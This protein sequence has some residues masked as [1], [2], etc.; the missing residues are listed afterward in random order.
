MKTAKQVDLRR[1]E[2]K[3]VVVNP[4]SG[5][6]I[7]GIL[8]DSNDCTIPGVRIVGVDR[9]RPRSKQAHHYD[10]DELVY[11]AHPLGE[12]RATTGEDGRF[13]LRGLADRPW[14]LTTSDL[15]WVIVPTR[16]PPVTPPSDDIVLRAVRSYQLSLSIRDSNSTELIPG[17]R[18]R[19]L[20]KGDGKMTS[21][22]FTCSCPDGRN[23]IAWPPLGSAMA[24]GSGFSFTMRVSAFGYEP[25]MVSVRFAPSERAISRTADL[26]PVPMGEIVLE[27]VLRTS[28]ARVA[29]QVS[30]VISRGGKQGWTFR[31][32]RDAR[33][34]TYRRWVPAGAWK[35]QVYPRMA[36]YPEAVAWEKT[37]DV[38]AGGIAYASVRLTSFG[39]VAVD[40]GGHDVVGLTVRVD[41]RRVITNIHDKN[42]RIVAIRAGVWP[43]VAEV[44]VDGETGLL[45]PPSSPTSAF[46]RSRR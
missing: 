22:R 17:S 10:T 27:E 44:V 12:A 46:A 35:V 21:T 34:S 36:F 26:T 42:P 4:E 20:L 23:T 6:T 38:P 32:D 13:E 3:R 37:I 39:S 33:T 2:S 19:I 1:G 9:R 18:A 7:R 40:R 29:G 11:S 24:E 43:Y 5:L 31:L 45:V 14:Y 25:R 28:G 41:G 30:M 16:R 8:L 15:R